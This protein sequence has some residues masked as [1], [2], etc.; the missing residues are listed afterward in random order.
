MNSHAR[1]DLVSFSFSK[2]RQTFAL[3]LSLSLTVSAIMMP[4][5]AEAAPQ[6]RKAAKVTK[7]KVAA[8]VKTAGG[9][10]A[11]E[12]GISALVKGKSAEAETKFRAAL[13]A[14]Q[15]SKDVTGEIDSLQM[16]AESLEAQ[17]RASE[18]EPLRQKALELAKTKYGEKGAGYAAQ[19]AGM[20]CYYTKKGNNAKAWE[21]VEK[22]NAVL[23]AAG[24]SAS[25]PLASAYCAIATG[26]LQ[27]MEGSRGLADQSFKKALELRESKL[28]ETS[29]MVLLVCKEYATLLEELERP[30]DA[31]RLKERLT[32]AEAKSDSANEPAKKAGAAI[33][34]KGSKFAKVVT[35]AKKASLAEE[36][37]KALAL[38]KEANS[39]AEKSGDQKKIAYT[40][41]KLGDAYS[42]LKEKDKMAAL[43]R[44]SAEIREKIKTDNTLAMARVLTRL[45]NV[46]LVQKN[47]DEAK[48]L[49][50]RALQ[51]EKAKNA[52]DDMLD[53]TLRSKY[54]AC[55]LTK[56]LGEGEKVCLK[57]VDL[58]SKDTSPIAGTRK[59]MTNSM[60]AGIYMQSGRTQE[61]I[62]MMQESAGHLTP[63]ASKQYGEA[64]AEVYKKVEREVD[65][66]EEKAMGIM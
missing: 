22:A 44:K 49:L 11:L 53:T 48:R 31:K 47:Y 30:D 55:M 18:S 1:K 14:F 12:N 20:S 56:D 57:L 2:M 54:S 40:L 8:P 65:A 45:A 58:A 39:M 38:W 13:A 5:P 29:P 41:F 17:R 27:K 24:G 15:K 36:N 64:T 63:E 46:E 59:A 60:L 6:K 35:E 23:G 66:A 10:A 16:L 3:T 61:G 42:M 37:D 33:N 34:L 4:S 25:N 51:I 32:V 7:K 52:S 26:R 19:L 50:D 43:Y 62:A 28:K 9:K 21:Y